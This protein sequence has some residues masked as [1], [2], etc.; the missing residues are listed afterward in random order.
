[1]Q[2]YISILL[3][4]TVTKSHLL[5]EDDMEVH[6]DG[7]IRQRVIVIVESNIFLPLCD[8]IMFRSTFVTL[9][10]FNII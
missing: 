5:H 9:S 10:F 3:K 4:F 2:P 8:R 6:L 7:R 1:M